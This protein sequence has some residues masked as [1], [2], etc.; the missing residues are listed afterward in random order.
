MIRHIVMFSFSEQVN[1]MN[2]EEVMDTIRLSA[3]SL[4]DKIPGMTAL[5][6]AYGCLDGTHDMIMTCDFI[7]TESIQAF[8][9]HPAHVAHRE[10]CA[11]FV[12][13]RAVIDY[14]L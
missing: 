5:S 3:Y 12:T 1:D 11:S 6:F 14:A 2:Q 4:L 13:N 8:S 9:I 7:N 10:L